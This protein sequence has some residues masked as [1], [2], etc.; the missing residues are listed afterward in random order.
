MQ[1]R[2]ALRANNAATVKQAN[3]TALWADNA[4]TAVKA[5]T[6]MK[7]PEQLRMIAKVVQLTDLIQRP[8]PRSSK[9]IARFLNFQIAYVQR[10]A[11]M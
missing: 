8:L 11:W 1:A 5:N 10:V 9:V 6:T 4:W 3:T 2:P 7:Q